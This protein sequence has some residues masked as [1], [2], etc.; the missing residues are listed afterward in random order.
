MAESKTAS[1]KSG[2]ILE[3]SRDFS[4]T[5]IQK[6]AELSGDHGVHHVHAERLM[7]HGLLVVSTITKI[8]GDIDFVSQEMDFKFLAP[9]YEGESVTARVILDQV[10]E[11]PRRY[12]IRMRCECVKSDGTV[13]VSGGGR[14]QIWK[15]T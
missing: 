10:L 5:D 4:R 15:P 6:F 12:K 1:L 8:G 9:V 14:G 13:V 2:T 3:Y 7:A 11:R